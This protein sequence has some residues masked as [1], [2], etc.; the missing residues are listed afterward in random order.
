[1]SASA[2]IQEAR[3]LLDG[4]MGTGVG[5]FIG[6]MWVTGLNDFENRCFSTLA[7]GICHKKQKDKE[8]SLFDIH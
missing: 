2:R 6:R 7:A 5:E 1:M 3:R 4:V 8:F